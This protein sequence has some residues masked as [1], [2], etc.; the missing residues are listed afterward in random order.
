MPNVAEIIKD[1]VTLEVRCI[2]RLYLNAYVPRLQR[3]GGVV[4]FLVRACRQKIASPAV[5]GQLPTAFKTRLRAWADQHGIPWVEFRKGDR[6]D[7]VVQRYRD[8]LAKP[9]GVGLIGVAQERASAWTATKTRQVQLLFPRRMTRA[10]PGRF[11]TRVIT[12]GVTP[13]L[14]IA[15]KRCQIKQYFTEERALR[16]ET[17]FNNTC[18][19]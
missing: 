11:S 18:D 7:A 2:D 13:S 12:A 15:C 6:N 17:T 3:S 9:S 8:R 1:H 10:T 5:F 14:H 4:D 19:F 16:T